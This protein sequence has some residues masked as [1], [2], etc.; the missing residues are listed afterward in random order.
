MKGDRAFNPDWV[1]YHKVPE[2]LIPITT[3]MPDRY[4][5]KKLQKPSDGS[6][7]LPKDDYMTGY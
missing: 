7:F 1:Q 3:G 5:P 4:L 2:K 6:E